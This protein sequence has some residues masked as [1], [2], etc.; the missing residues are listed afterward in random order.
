MTSPRLFYYFFPFKTVQRLRRKI[1][2]GVKTVTLRSLL[3][4]VN[5]IFKSFL[6]R[7]P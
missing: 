4:D 1:R 3:M 6:D 7:E 5:C 2:H